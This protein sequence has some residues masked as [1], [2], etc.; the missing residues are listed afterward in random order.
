MGGFPAV[1]VLVDGH[2]LQARELLGVLGGNGFVAW[3]VEV[4]RRDA[5]AFFAVQVLQ[6]G[7]GDL[8]GAFL[9][10]VFIDDSHRWLSQ[11]RQRRR[12][13]F[14][15]VTALF[16]QGQE[17]FVFP[18]QQH[19]TNVV[20]NEGDGRTASTGVQYRHVF[21]QL[22][23]ELLGLGFAAVFLLGVGPGGKE[24]PACTAGGF[25]VRGDHF[26]ARL[27]QV[28]PVLDAFRVALAHKEHDGRGVRRAR[29]RQA[30]LP[31]LRDQLAEL[32]Q[33]VDIASQGQGYHV[34][35]QTID[36]RTGLFARTAVGLLKGH[37]FVAGGGPVLVKRLV[38]L[39]IKLTSRV[40]GRV[41]QGGFGQHGGGEQGGGQ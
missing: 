10:D 4:L 13:D 41:E 19:V 27:D 30:G 34:S 5:L 24:V 11:D 1:E 14:E 40:V 35:F 37:G 32:V 2:Q 17:G 3:A 36:H 20:V 39:G 21:I 29:L 15:L 25:R 22:L 12:D 26:N 28:I 33:L 7:F 18:G 8:A 6:V 16:F 38:V 9:V 23:H 31:V